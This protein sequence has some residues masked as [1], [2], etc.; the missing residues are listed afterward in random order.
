MMKKRENKRAR[1]GSFN[2]SQPKLESGNRFQFHQKF[3]VPAPSL[4]GA[5]VPKFKK[6]S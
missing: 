4:A 2:F 5:P 1:K 3:L 6:Y